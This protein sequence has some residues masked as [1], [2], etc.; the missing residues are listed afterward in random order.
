MQSLLSSNL[1]QFNIEKGLYTQQVG[2]TSQENPVMKILPK[3][4][5]LYFI[6][7]EQTYFVRT[8]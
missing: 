2:F 4:A 1:Q 5:C 8:L 7:M 6:A 3:G